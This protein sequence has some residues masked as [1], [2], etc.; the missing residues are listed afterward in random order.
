ME[1]TVTNGTTS[2]PACPRCGGPTTRRA[3]SKSGRP[4]WGCNRYPDCDGLIDIQ[5]VG[6]VERV[7]VETERRVVDY[8]HERA[9]DRRFE[10]ALAYSLKLVESPGRITDD[11]NGLRVD[12]RVTRLGVELADSLMVDLNM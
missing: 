3:S 1:G 6:L 7:E 10:A 5:E 11:H 8:D 12:S 4:F 2:A 9:R